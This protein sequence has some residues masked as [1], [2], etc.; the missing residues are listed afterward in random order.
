MPETPQPR[1]LTTHDYY[2][3]PELGPRYQLIAGDMFMAPAPDRS[4][5]H[6]SGNLEYALRKYLE[7][8]P[9]GVVYDAP[10]D[11]ELNEVNVY[12]PDIIF[13]SQARSSI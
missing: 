11:L 2:D 1:Q 7:R 9:I 4:H 13:V 10:F 6:I 12:Q 8:N 3:L 5:Q